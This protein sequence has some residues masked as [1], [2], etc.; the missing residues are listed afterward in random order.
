MNVVCSKKQ[1]QHWRPDGRVTRETDKQTV[2]ELRLCG[3]NVPEIRSKCNKRS[4]FAQVTRVQSRR[5]PVKAMSDICKHWN[6][7]LGALF[8]EEAVYT[9][10]RS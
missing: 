3:Q 4:Q 6:Q 5:R 2:T 1:I 10:P 8:D 7:S 9:L